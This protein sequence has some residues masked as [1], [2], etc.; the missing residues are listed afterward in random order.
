MRER[1]SESEN[2]KNKM[3]GRQLDGGSEREKQKGKDRIQ[4]IRERGR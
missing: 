4:E 2:K 3:S 1:E